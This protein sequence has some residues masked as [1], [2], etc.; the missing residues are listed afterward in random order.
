MLARTP[1]TPAI[2]PRAVGGC[3]GWVPWVGG[4][5]LRVWTHAWPAPLSAAVDTQVFAAPVAAHAV[6]AVVS[7]YASFTSGPATA[8]PKAE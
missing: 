2:R 8:R 1:D 5:G 6:F 7:L 3:R 4:W